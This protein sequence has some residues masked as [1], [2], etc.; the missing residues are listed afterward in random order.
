MSTVAHYA[1]LAAPRPKIYGVAE[2]AKALATTDDN[3]ILAAIAEG[4]IAYSTGM[5]SVPPIQTMGQ[6]PLHPFIDPSDG[7]QMCIK[8]GY[9]E[10]DEHTVVKMAP[11]S[12]LSNTRASIGLPVN[13]GLNLIFSQNTGRAEAILLDEGL[14]T[15]IR[16]AACGALAASLM[17]PKAL[18]AIGVLGAGIQ[19][20]WQLRMLKCV[21]S[22]RKVF[23]YALERLEEFRL[24][25]AAEGWE[26]H[27]CSSAE[28]VVKDVELLLTV[29][30]TR[31]PIVKASWLKARG[32]GG[33]GSEGTKPLH[34]NCIG[35][36][37]PGK[38]EL[39]AECVAMAKLLC[40]DA[41]VQTVE[42]GEF[43][44]AIAAD[45][46]P[47]E[48]VVE[49]GEL[50]GMKD[51]FPNPHDGRGS[52]TI[53]DTSGVSVQDIMITKCVYQALVAMDAARARL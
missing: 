6:P 19:A 25:M 17:A 52:L 2:I 14:L 23:L 18:T 13:T 36:D 47:V 24:E 3:E 48:S 41:L 12:F 8:S 46:I 45:L 35:A 10:G 9:I 33:E 27:I 7:S 32:L 28:E 16:T 11:G 22:C 39:E 40:T 50:L 34:I 51:S 1:A 30:T 42:R 38:G 20:R 31:K 43:Q 44:H 5:V 37:A 26:V 21:T 4:F 29:T 53:F 49:I 15:E